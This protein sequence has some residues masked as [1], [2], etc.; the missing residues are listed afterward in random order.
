MRS[1]SIFRTAVLVG[2]VAA[3]VACGSDSVEPCTGASCVDAGSTADAKLDGT[4]PDAADGAVTDGSNPTDAAD[5]ATTDGGAPS[6]R[7]ATLASGN[8]HNCAITSAKGVRC[9]GSNTAGQLGNGGTAPQ[10]GAVDVVGIGGSNPG[11]ASLALGTDSSCALL[12]NGTI[13]C[14]GDGGGGRLG[15]GQTS[16][17]PTPVTVTGITNATDIVQHAYH[18]CARLA[19]TSVKCWGTNDG[20]LANGLVPDSAVPVAVPSSTNTVSL[21]VGWGHT[22]LVDAGGGVRCAG[23]YNNWGQVGDGSNAKRLSLVDVLGG[24]ESPITDIA[25]VGTSPYTTCAVTKSGKLRCWGNNQTGSLASGGTDSSVHGYVGP[26][27]AGLSD[28]VQVTGGSA[29]CALVKSGQVYCWGPGTR[30]G[31]GTGQPRYTPTPVSGL[32]DA[33]EISANNEHACARRVDGTIWCWG[34]NSY[35]QLGDGTV[36][37][38]R[39]APVKNTVF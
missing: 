11:A 16:P 24:V 34:D 37:S 8:L 27:I 39:L 4:L 36:T 10:T 7:P 13:K 6:L 29:M 12:V 14:W 26:E 5:G 23:T 33:T 17:S 19:D 38:P 25:L 1:S 31:D 20:R 3:Q 21:A 32:A 35:R 28:V 2:L 22:C 15:N 18:V 9:W 30:N